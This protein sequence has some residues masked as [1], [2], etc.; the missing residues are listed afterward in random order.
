MISLAA[1]Q[2]YELLSAT[3]L[4]VLVRHSYSNRTINYPAMCSAW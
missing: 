4:Q 1:V 2:L 3:A